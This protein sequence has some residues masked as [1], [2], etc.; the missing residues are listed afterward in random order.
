MSIPRH[1]AWRDSEGIHYSTADAGRQRNM[2]EPVELLWEFDAATVEEAMCLHFLRLGRHPYHPN[3]SHRVVQIADRCTTPK[4]QGSAGSAAETSQRHDA[5]VGSCQ[6]PP[7]KQLQR[8]VIHR[9][10]MHIGQCA[11][12]ELRR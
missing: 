11:A 2:R 1:Q 4:D 3:G 8:T 6:S 7:N 10:P 5:S 12:A 9:L